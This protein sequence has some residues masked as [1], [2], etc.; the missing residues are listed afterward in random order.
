V[1]ILNDTL[2][3]TPLRYKGQSGNR[4]I[5]VAIRNEEHLGVS[6]EYA[7]HPSNIG[8]FIVRFVVHGKGV[9]PKNYTHLTYREP[10][11]FI[12]PATNTESAEVFKGFRLNKV[13]ITAF[14]PA[15]QRHEV[16]QVAEKLGTWAK[17]AAWVGEQIVAEGFTLTVPNLRS[18]LREMVVLPVTSGEITDVLEFPDLKAPEEQVKA[19]KLVKKPEPEPDEEDEDGDDDK[20]DDDPEWLN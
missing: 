8:C 10:A 2:A 6:M 1:E 5:D 9:D 12:I 7:I 15:I 18:T 16:T 14:S 3:T 17:L 4:Y 13:A 19:L 20:D 11:K